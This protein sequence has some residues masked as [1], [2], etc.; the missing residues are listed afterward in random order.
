MTTLNIRPARSAD[1]PTLA[2]WLGRA[3]VLPQAPGECLWVA[4]TPGPEAGTEMQLRATLRLVPALGLRLPRVSYHVGCTV[5]AAPELGLFQTQRTLLLGHDHTGATELAD[6]AWAQ[7][8]VPVSD[9]ALALRMLLTTALTHIQKNRAG[10]ARRVVVELPGPRDAAGQSPF[11]QGLGR[12]FY[13]ADP[14]SA[15]A[16]HGPDWR[17]HVAALLPRHALYTSF[18]PPSAE[19]AIAQ[20]HTSALVLREVLEDAG[21]RYSH[22]VNVEDGGPILEAEVEDLALLRKGV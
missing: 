19:A 8:D 10:Y 18:L 20:V 2:D 7:A 15:F 5:H 4:H 16:T 11:W 6:I 22:H 17:S 14:A 9:Q 1:L 12:H 13:S 21:L 3:P